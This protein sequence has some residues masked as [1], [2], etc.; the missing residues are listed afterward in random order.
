M[1]TIKQH[2]S[3]DWEVHLGATPESAVTQREDLWP[4]RVPNADTRAAIEELEGGRGKR[5]DGIDRLFEDL[6]I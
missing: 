5:F 6:G 2:S 1:A 4:H 3:D